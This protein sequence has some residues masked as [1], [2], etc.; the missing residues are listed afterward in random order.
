MKVNLK[1]MQGRQ[2]VVRELS[3]K[4]GVELAEGMLEIPA[5]L[6]NG[7]L[8]RDTVV[9]GVERDS[10]L[11]TVVDKSNSEVYITGGGIVLTDSIAKKLNVK[12]GDII[13]M[14]SA[15]A[16]NDNLFIRIEAIVP[17]YIG[18]NCYMLGE[19]L[20]VRLGYCDLLTSAILKTDGF[21][22]KRLKDELV[23]AGNIT[24]IEETGQI[25]DKYV[26][27]M[28]QFFFMLWVMAAI[29]VITGFAIIY[30][31]S[32]IS[33][34]ERKREL[35]SLRVMGMGIHEVQQVVSFE[36]NFVAFIGM[37]V[38]IPLTYGFYYSLSEK[39]NTDL[40]TIP[41]IIKPE[42]FIYAFLGTMMAQGL[43]YLN[44]KRKIERLDMVGVLKE[45]E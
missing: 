42:I 18:I 37:L 44:I 33:L 25:K 19:E 14:E 22:D 8:S 20:S 3:K 21:N 39:M 4:R 27:A 5:K 26:D 45:R 41:V 31:S 34:S 24:G 28:D 43:A 11:Y 23:S 16:K 13:E 9:I 36:Q 10:S 17:Q 32:V 35:A 15:M 38:G 2:E 30:N 29:A 40:Y 6:K 7:H 12:P 1:N